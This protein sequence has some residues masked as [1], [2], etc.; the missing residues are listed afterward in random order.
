RT[1][2][3]EIAIKEA[4]E[5]VDVQLRPTVAGSESV[6]V[7]GQQEQ[8]EGSNLEH[9]SKK[10]VG[11]D[12]RRNLGSTLSQTLS[13]LAGFDE[14]SMGSAPGRPVIRGLG[15]ERVLI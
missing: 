1:L 15:D 5:I 9:A 2:T 11:S 7:V 14:R 3:K 4:D 10:M 12:L 6:D 13:N 8:L